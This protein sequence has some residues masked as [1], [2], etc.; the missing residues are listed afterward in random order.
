MVIVDVRLVIMEG[1]MA[2]NIQWVEWLVIG[3]V[4]NI[5]RCY[6]WIVSGGADMGME[7]SVK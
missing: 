1:K 2:G 6:R 7:F 4:G 5:N 3:M